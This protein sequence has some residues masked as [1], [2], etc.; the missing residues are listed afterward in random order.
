MTDDEKITQFEGVFKLC[1]ESLMMNIQTW[2]D[3]KI[4][5]PEFIQ[6]YVFAL[7]HVNHILELIENHRAEILEVMRDF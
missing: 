1:R 6:K 2:K 3:C 4:A 5:S 7:V